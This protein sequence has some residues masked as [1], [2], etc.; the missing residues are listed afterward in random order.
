VKKKSPPNIEK[1][2][3]DL[4]ATLRSFQAAVDELVRTTNTKLKAPTTKPKPHSKVIQKAK[5]NKP[6]R[7]KTDPRKWY[8]ISVEMG[9]E[10]RA[11]K[12]IRKARKMYDLHKDIGKVY[13]PTHMAEVIPPKKGE[14]V[15]SGHN[16]SRHEAKEVGTLRAWQH[17][18]A[19]GSLPHICPDGY[20]IQVYQSHKPPNQLWS[21]RVIKEGN[22]ESLPVMKKRKKFP[23]YLIVQMNL[24]ANVFHAITGDKLIHCILM[25]NDTPTAMDNEEAALLLLEQATITRPKNKESITEDNKM[26]EIFAVGDVITVMDGTWKKNSGTVIRL[27]DTVD[28]KVLVNLSV[29]GVLVALEIPSLILVK[30]I[31]K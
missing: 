21:W 18:E 6:R 25:S 1:M 16:M 9:V 4:A 19:R 30:G 3:A 22:E 29:M 8:V 26:G 13:S 17:S 5:S 15:A 11:T 12:H 24:T 31:I 27:P 2:I 10:D 20:R 14:V 28:G 7:P 23:G